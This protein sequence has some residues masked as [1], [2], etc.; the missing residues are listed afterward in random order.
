M[1]RQGAK[2]L[3]LDAQGAQGDFV[4]PDACWCA[5]THFFFRDVAGPPEGA[6]RRVAGDLGLELEVSDPGS[7]S[8]YEDEGSGGRRMVLEEDLAGWSHGRGGG[9][10][11]KK[12]DF[13]AA[14]V[15]FGG[16]ARGLR[17]GG[18][19]GVGAV[20]SVPAPG[21]GG[22]VQVL[23]ALPLTLVRAST[24]GGGGRGTGR[25]ADDIDI[26]GTGS[27]VVAPAPVGVDGGCGCSCGVALA[28]VRREVVTEVRRVRDELMGA[29]SLLL[30]ERELG[31]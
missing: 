28:G 10:V 4:R 26:G 23:P 14:R 18:L 1:G 20:G 27:R 31:T 2:Q 19:G 6:L 17:G 13:G 8:E 24:N 11:L 16:P 29:I 9:R 3:V 21:I 7:D 22:A 15:L 30:A 5:Q 12:A 25:A